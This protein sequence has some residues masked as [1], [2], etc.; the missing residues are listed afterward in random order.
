MEKL[1][2][3]NLKFVLWYKN[4]FSWDD[5]IEEHDNYQDVYGSGFLH[6]FAIFWISI[7]NILI[8]PLFLVSCIINF[9]YFLFFLNYY[10]K[11]RKKKEEEKEIKKKEYK[12][13]LIEDWINNYENTV[14][15]DNV[16]LKL[17]TADTTYGNRHVIHSSVKDFVISESIQNVEL[18]ILSFLTKYNNNYSIFQNVYTYDINSKRVN[19][20]NSARRSLYDLYA[21][22]LYYYPE[23]KFEDVIKIVIKMIDNYSLNTSFC[24]DVC[25][26]VFYTDR[27]SNHRN[28]NHNLEFYNSYF[29]HQIFDNQQVD[30][31]FFDLLNYFEEKEN[32]KN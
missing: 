5:E 3:L 25:K 31:T 4:R 32:G 8:I 15:K 10:E 20:R 21:L 18:L 17:V 24:H 6:A 27:I 12:K 9:I 23:T 28:F 16:I 7:F 1:F 13:K 30:L 26:Y 2:K 11:R 19:C 22:C 14:K 29:K